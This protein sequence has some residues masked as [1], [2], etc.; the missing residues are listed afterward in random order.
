MSYFCPEC[1]QDL[2][3]ASAKVGPLQGGDFCVCESCGLA[4]RFH[5][6]A[7]LLTPRPA[8]NLELDGLD[9][10]SR[11]LILERQ[12]SIRRRQAKGCS[13]H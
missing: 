7:G 3:T 6:E 9:S 13:V 10:L 4:I 1:D 2:K 11:A 5:L 8:Q 12:G